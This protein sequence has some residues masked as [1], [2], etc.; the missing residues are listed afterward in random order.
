[1]FRCYD[2]RLCFTE[3]RPYAYL[4]GLVSGASE[5]FHIKDHGPILDFGKREN[6]SNTP[7]WF[8]MF[9]GQLLVISTPYLPGKH[10]AESP[11]QLLALVI[12][13]EELHARGGVHGDIR[14]FNVVFHKE[15][16]VGQ[17]RTNRTFDLEGFRA[18]LIDFD[19]AGMDGADTKYPVGYQH[20]SDG[21]RRGIAGQPITSHQEWCALR[22]ILFRFHDIDPPLPPPRSW[23]AFF[24]GGNPWEEV[25]ALMCARDKL[26][27]TFALDKFPSASE[28]LELKRFLLKIHKLGWVVSPD[29]EFKDALQRNGL[30]GRVQEQS[31]PSRTAINR[32]TESSA[33]QVLNAGRQRRAKRCRTL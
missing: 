18:Y 23:K 20:V 25:Y 7:Y 27:K 19:F 31:S 17:D 21:A 11:L 13:L 14:G 2:N 6:V 29:C 32:A 24:S 1:V 22:F 28:R 15:A 5:L 30:L 26:G 3:R 10:Y 4:N 12:Q 33:K 8:W 16:I 9:R